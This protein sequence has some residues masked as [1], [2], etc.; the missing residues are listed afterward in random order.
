[1]VKLVAYALPG[2]LELVNE[3]MPTKVKEIGKI[4]GVEFA[5]DDTP[6]IVLQKH[7]LHIAILEMN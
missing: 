4:L 5:L 6:A 3:T 7:G 2:V 1:M